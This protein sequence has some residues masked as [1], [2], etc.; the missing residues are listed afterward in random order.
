[1]PAV[2]GRHIFSY[3]LGKVYDALLDDVKVGITKSTETL[4]KDVEKQLMK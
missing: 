1:V 4:S 2:K 3:Y